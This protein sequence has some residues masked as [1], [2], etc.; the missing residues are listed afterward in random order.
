MASNVA[1]KPIKGFYVYGWVNADWG[2]VFFYVGKGSGDRYKD[3]DKRGRAFQAIL[4]N[5]SCYPVIIQDGLTEEDA[6]CMEADV[7]ER[8]IFEGGHP[9]MD[10][11]G[12]YTFLKKIAIKRG[13]EEAKAQGKYKGRKKI[14]VDPEVFDPVYREVLNGGRK[15]SW[16]MEKLG[17]KRNTYYKAVAAYK[18]RHPEE[19]SVDEA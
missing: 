7:K 3:T 9:I 13:I 18:E 16:A 10:G 2:G 17:L 15:N 8:L 14:E 12:R 19:V 5:W 1:D 11:E 4:D 6:D